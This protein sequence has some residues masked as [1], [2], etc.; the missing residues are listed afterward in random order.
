MLTDHWLT[1]DVNIDTNCVGFWNFNNEPA[2]PG[3]IEDVSQTAPLV[4]GTLM[5]TADVVADTGGN[6]KGASLVLEIPGPNNIG[7]GWLD[8]GTLTD[9][10]NNKEDF[11]GG[12]TLTF[13]AKQPDPGYTALTDQPDRSIVNFGGLGPRAWQAGDVLHQVGFAINVTGDVTWDQQSHVTNT[14]LLF[15]GNNAWQHWAFVF[16]PNLN[17]RELPGTLRVYKNGVEKSSE[18]GIKGRGISAMESE[19]NRFTVGG[20]EDAEGYAGRLDDVGLFNRALTAAEINT[21]RAATTGTVVSDVTLTVPYLPLIEDVYD[22]EPTGQ[23]IVNFKDFAVFA[24]EWM[25]GP[26]LFPF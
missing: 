8:L 16:D 21:V 10:P 19:V 9:F 18:T 23:K 1:A 17:D 2:H 7:E 20:G 3:T 4:T 25:T 13:W 6:G 22:E 5:G 26:F 12:C 11:R 14:A 15:F 24:E